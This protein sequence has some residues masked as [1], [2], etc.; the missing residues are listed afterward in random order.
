MRRALAI[1]LPALVLL[2]A[3]CGG[4][5][6]PGSALSDSLA[7]LPKDAPFAVA[8]DTDLQGDQWGA[9]GKL[10]DRFPFGDQIKG[11][12]VQRLE[13]SSRG[14]SFDDDIRP[15]LGNPLVVGPGSAQAI[16]GE[17]N[18]FVAAGK[19]KDK[20]AL[21]DLIDKLGPKKVGEASGA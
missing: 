2:V 17:P 18:A 20:G 12:V 8:I 13:Q 3:G 15:V 10:V 5:D 14:L 7:Y 6:D 21:D 11:T 19:A 4:S 1:V 16:T 9:L